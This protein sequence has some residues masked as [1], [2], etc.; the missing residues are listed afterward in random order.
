[1][2]QPTRMRREAEL[3]PQKQASLEEHVSKLELSKKELVQDVERL[4]SVSISWPQFLHNA[5]QGF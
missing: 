5:I 2:T 4:S 1:M 3:G